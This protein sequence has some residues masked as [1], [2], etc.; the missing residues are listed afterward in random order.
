MCL[1]AAQLSALLE[2][3]DWRRVTRDERRR[4]R[5]KRDGCWQRCGE[6]NRERRTR[7]QMAAN[8]L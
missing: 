5:R 3:L 8:M 6:V 4:R 7:R 1:S 2:G